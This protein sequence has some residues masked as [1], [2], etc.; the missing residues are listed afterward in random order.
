[1][2][3]PPAPDTPVH[4]IGASGRSGRALCAALV[5]AGIAYVPLVR[6]P[7]RWRATGLPGVARCIDLTSPAADIACALHDA[8]RIVSTAHARHVGAILAAA[9]PAASLVCL[10]STRMFTRWPDAHG[11]GVAR[12]QQA[13]L[14]SGRNGVILHPTMI[15]GAQGENNIRRLL[16]LIRRLPVLP[17]PS[18][19]RALVQ[20]IFQDDVTRALM[21]A[22][23]RD[24][25]GGH[26]LVI[27][28]GQAVAYRDLVALVARHAGLR[29]RPVLGIPA[30]VL[31]G[32][33]HVASCLP[34]LPHVTPAEIRRLTEDK[35]FDITPMRVA[36]GFTPRTLDEGLRQFLGAS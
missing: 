22:L 11:M 27:A 8:R 12:G 5:R 16:G 29:R 7:A 34:G 23:A 18:G 15:Y 1:M 25:H 24:W 6:D 35:A 14:S 32:M 4:V 36:L 26:A 9:P 2:P 30:P 13:L 31:M 3:T 28:G 19:G 10:G 17:L 21:A 33:C 20:P